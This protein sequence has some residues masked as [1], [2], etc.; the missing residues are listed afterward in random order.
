MLNDGSYQLKLP[1]NVNQPEELIQDNVS[2][3]GNAKVIAPE[4]L[5]IKLVASL[6]QALALYK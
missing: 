1:Y 2:F 3:S 6:Q 4:S 5:Q